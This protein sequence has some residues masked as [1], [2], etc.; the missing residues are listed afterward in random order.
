MSLTLDTHSKSVCNEVLNLWYVVKCSAFISRFLLKMYRHLQLYDSQWVSLAAANTCQTRGTATSLVILL[1]CDEYF[2]G[3]LLPEQ[4]GLVRRQKSQQ[5]TGELCTPQSIGHTVTQIRV[6]SI[7]TWRDTTLTGCCNRASLHTLL[8]ASLLGPRRHRHGRTPSLGL[9][10]G[11]Q[12]KEG[13]W[14]QHW[15]KSIL[16]FSLHL[17]VKSANLAH[18][19]HS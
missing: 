19:C 13:A 11:A 18:C 12:G 6:T 8:E 10:N 5:T 3:R 7:A 16:F 4:V 9:A 17:W 2:T 1:I 15:L 14:V